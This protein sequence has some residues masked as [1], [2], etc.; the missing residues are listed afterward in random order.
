MANPN[1]L[2][3]LFIAMLV[4]VAGCSSGGYSQEEIDQLAQC[5]TEKGG[6]F[7]G[8]FWCPKC[9]QVKKNF[10]GAMKYL[11]YVECDARGENEQSELCIAKGID[12]YATFVFNDDTNK[13]NWLVGVPTFE[14]LATKADCPAPQ[15]KQ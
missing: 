15:K 6:V 13:D 10:A 3:L 5:I 8:T 2:I 12:K 1:K 14:E 11:T 7:Y 4:V 9:A